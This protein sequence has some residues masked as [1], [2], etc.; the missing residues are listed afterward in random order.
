[1]DARRYILKQTAVIAAGHGLGAAAIVG[2]FAL[3]GSYDSTVLLGAIVGSVVAIANFFFMSLG[4]MM[5][6]DKAQAQDVK[7]GQTTMKLSFS[8]RMIFMA[9]VL[10]AFAKSGL[11]NIIALVVPLVLT[12]PILI[13]TEYFRKSGDSSK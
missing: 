11:C 13:I 5:A 7:G 1:M 9:I 2:I 4:A 8:G 10:I 3:L 12:Q 6:A